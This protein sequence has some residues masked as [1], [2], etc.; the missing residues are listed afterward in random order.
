[1]TNANASRLMQ[2]SGH[3]KIQSNCLYHFP[4]EMLSVKNGCSHESFLK[5]KNLEK[6]FGVCLYVFEFGLVWKH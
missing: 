3:M 4:Y 6:E 1:M 5:S 2:L